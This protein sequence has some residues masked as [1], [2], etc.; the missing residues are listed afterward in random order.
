MC[1]ITGPVNFRFMARR[2]RKR[3]IKL[4]KPNIN[5]TVI[6]CLILPG[7]GSREYVKI[8]ELAAV[9]DF[10]THEF[11]PQQHRLEIPAQFLIIRGHFFDY[12]P[13]YVVDYLLFQH[14]LSDD[15][16]VLSDFLSQCR[17]TKGCGE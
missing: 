11:M 10:A 8:S 15:R 7:V 9:I 12:E 4:N 6:V 16:L 17:A 2:E 3:N 13:R 14:M 1:Q 5:N